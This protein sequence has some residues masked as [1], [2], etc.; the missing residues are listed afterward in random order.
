MIIFFNMIK[1]ATS[2]CDQT[3]FISVFMFSLQQI[4]N[5]KNSISLH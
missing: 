5:D 2:V 1:N 3:F 4:E